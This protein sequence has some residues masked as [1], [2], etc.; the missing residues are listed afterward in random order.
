VPGLSGIAASGTLIL[1]PRGF[2]M[3]ARDC[4]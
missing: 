3:S 1:A 4:C 2:G